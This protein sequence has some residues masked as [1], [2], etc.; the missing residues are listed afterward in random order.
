ML[1]IRLRPYAT[2][3][4]PASSPSLEASPF[5]TSQPEIA[6]KCTL[7]AAVS[8]RSSAHCK[9]LCYSEPAYPT[10]ALVAVHPWHAAAQIPSRRRRRR[11]TAASSTLGGSG[12]AERGVAGACAPPLQSKSPKTYARRTVYL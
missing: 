4:P 3:V 7:N 6:A 8:Q 11:W 9:Q 10:P 1:R 5:S 12:G 2:L